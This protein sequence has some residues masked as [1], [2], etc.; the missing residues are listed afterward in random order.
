MITWSVSFTIA[1]NDGTTRYVELV[2]DKGGVRQSMGS[3]DDLRVA[4]RLPKFSE[5]TQA[6]GFGFTPYLPD[7]VASYNYRF[8]ATATNGHINVLGSSAELSPAA[9]NNSALIVS[10]L[11][12]DAGIIAY[13][14]PSVTVLI[15]TSYIDYDPGSVSAEGSNIIASLLQYGVEIKTFT[16]ISAESL[17]ALLAD[18][19]ILLIPENEVNV[20]LGDRVPL[21]FSNEAAAVIT[22]F[23]NKGGV[24]I[25]MG[26]SIASSYLNPIFSW[27]LNMYEGETSTISK[28]SY[29]DANGFAEC[30]A[31]LPQNDAVYGL[32][33]EGLP[34]GSIPIY[35]SFRGAVYVAS[36]P[37]G[38]G[39]VI[40]IGW[41]WYN[42]EP[43]GEGDGGWLQV[44]YTAVT[45]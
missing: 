22:N 19:N 27:S 11:L 20:F 28:T 41:D 34:A 25:S 42:A 18:I 39:S 30:A 33:P 1:Y 5:F 8:T 29:A 13:L 7:D 10:E 36:M 35:E 12:A 3:I 9:V 44:L 31:T 24:L 23:I 6:Y 16:D 4:R 43:I 38:Q 21:V 2:Q 45:L 40:Y 32:M 15:N 14:V 17:T 26:A 37:Y